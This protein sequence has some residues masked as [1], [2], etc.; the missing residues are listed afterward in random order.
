MFSL[1]YDGLYIY[2]VTN[3]SSKVTSVLTSNILVLYVFDFSILFICFIF[4]KIMLMIS[5]HEVSSSNLSIL[6]I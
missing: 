6:V 1:R 5:V 2:Q 4:F 3:S